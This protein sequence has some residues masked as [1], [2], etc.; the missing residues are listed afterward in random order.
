MALRTAEAHGLPVPAALPRLTER[1]DVHAEDLAAVLHRRVDAW[2]AAAVTAGRARPADLVGGLIPPARNVTDPDTAGALTGGQ[3]LIEERADVVVAQAR[4]AGA[5][6]LGRLGP[7]PDDP[8]QLAE[9]TAVARTVAAYRDRYEVTDPIRPLGH[10]APGDVQRDRSYAI[11]AG[12]MAALRDPAD[13]A[14]SSSPV[15]QR[16]RPPEPPPPLS[17]SPCHPSTGR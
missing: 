7:Q 17:L 5:P 12:A 14:L 2:T 8:D 15:V 1:A 9:W 11:I 4:T 3:A 6:W 10:R 13:A 16:R